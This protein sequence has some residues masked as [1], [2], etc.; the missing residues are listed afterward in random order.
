MLLNH[1][2]F[3]AI[4]EEHLLRGTRVL[5]AFEKVDNIFL[6]NEFRGNCPRFLEGFVSTIFLTVAVRSLVGRGVSCLCPEFFIEPDDYSAFYL[7]GH[8]LDGLVEL[9]WVRRSAI[10]TA[11]A[12]YQSLVCDQRQVEER[13]NRPSAPINHVLSLCCNQPGFRPRRNQYKVNIG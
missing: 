1:L 13:A 12:E 5:S 7:L 6:R 10:E 2:C 8:V 9:C 4:E 3:G 11:K